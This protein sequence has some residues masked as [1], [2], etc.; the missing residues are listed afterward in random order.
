MLKVAR[1]SINSNVN[2]KF[3]TF[4]LGQADLLIFISFKKAKKG[5]LRTTARIT[6]GAGACDNR[7][8]FIIVVF[9]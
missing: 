9:G 3:H 8:K 4:K 2:K 6:G 7:N 5:K 1:F